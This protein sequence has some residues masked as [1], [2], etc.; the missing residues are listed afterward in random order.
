MSHSFVDYPE[1]TNCLAK[2]DSFF[3]MQ[4]N[5]IWGALALKQ[6]KDSP[7]KIAASAQRPA[8]HYQMTYGR[9]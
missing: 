3:F 9:R 6:D 4:M 1:T 7:A 5:N 8:T 2:D